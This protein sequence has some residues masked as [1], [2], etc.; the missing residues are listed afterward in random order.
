MS[1]QN[2]E[3]TASIASDVIPNP[4][5]FGE[6]GE[7]GHVV[8]DP[9]ESLESDDESGE[10][11][12]D[13]E[14]GE[15]ELASEESSLDDEVHNSDSKSYKEMQSMYSKT[16]TKNSELEGQLGQIEDRLSALGGL[17]N[18]VKALTYV[19]SDPDYRALT[20]KKAGQTIPGI[21]DDSLSPEAKEALDLVRKTVQ[22][23]LQPV[24][25]R[26]Q[27]EKIDPLTDQIRQS[28]LNDI[29]DS[30]LENYG[31]QFQEQLPTIEKLAKSLPA[32]ILNNPTYKT[33]ESLFH[34][35]LREDGKA[36]AYYLSG[37]QDK[38]NGKKGRVTG[39]PKGGR[40]G[41]TIPKFNKPKTMFDAARIADKKAAYARRKK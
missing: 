24:M 40:V 12:L 21:D 7:F 17:D 8:V 14:E 1:E 15:E 31:E 5:E 27:R 41:E 34:D 29:A 9:D 6:I 3:G 36:E 38:V 39:S 28:S 35:S 20:A 19:Q 22:A 16:Q 18:V 11:S 37:Y 4:D 33:M 23:E 13:E 32:E 10:L 26:L 2:E 30:L 25:S